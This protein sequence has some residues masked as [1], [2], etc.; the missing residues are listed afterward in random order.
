MLRWTARIL[1]VFAVLSIVAAVIVHFVLKSDWLERVILAAV[2]ERIGM[3]V[4]C[5]SLSVRWGGTTTVHRPAV[6]TPLTNEEVLSADRIEIR[7]EAI[8]LLILGRSIRVRSVEVDSPRVNMRRDENGRWSIQD[9][10][11]RLSTSLSSSDSSAGSQGLPRVMVRDALVRVTEPNT[12]VQ[13]V[14]PLDLRADAEG[15]LLW[16]FD[17]RWSQLAEVKGRV[18]QGSDWTHDVGFSVS[19][20]GSLVRR[21]LGSGPAPIRAAGRWEGKVLQEAVTGTLQLEELVVG[22]AAARG[23]VRVEAKADQICLNPQGLVLSDPHLAGREIHLADGSVR[24]V[25]RQVCVEQ[26]SVVSGRLTARVDGT[27]NWIAGTGELAASWAQLSDG[28]SSQH[29]GVCH[30]S[31]GSPQFG[32]RTAAVSVTAQAETSVGDLALTA[33][34]DGAGADWQKSQWRVSTPTCVWTLDGGQVDLGGAGAEVHVDWPAIRLTSLHVPETQV[35]SAIVQFDP[36]TRAWSANLT[37]DDVSQVEP[38]GIEPLDI[39]LSAEGD[40]HTAH[41]SELRIAQGERIVTARGDLSFR[42]WGFQDVQLTADWP[43]GSAPDGPQAVAKTPGRWH[44]EGAVFGR[45][46]PLAAELTGRLTGQSVAVGKEV[47]EQVEVPVR[48]TA[49][50]REVRVTSDAMDL[51]GGRWL[52]SGRHDLRSNQTEAVVTVDGLSLESVAAIAGL[53]RISQGRT[54]AQIQLAMRDFDIESVVAAG[55]WNAQDVCISPWHIPRARGELHFSKGLA[56]FDQIVLEQENGQ[57]QASVEFR[58]DDP[59]SVCVELT[60]RTW[61]TQLDGDRVT[62]C[63][64]GRARLRVNAID[65]TVN[66][67]ADLSGPVLWAGQPLAH[68]RVS[69]FV[70]K[71]TLDVQELHVDTLGGSVA[72]RAE[73]PLDD[74]RSSTAT[75]GWQG[76][77]P[78][79]LQRWVPQF[80]RFEGL[81]SGSLDVER[82]DPATRPPEPMRFVLDAHAEGGRFGPAHVDSCRLV[83][84]LGS[85]RLLVDEADFDILDGQFEAR[86]RVS[87]HADGYHGSLVVDFNNLSLNQLVH[88]IDPNA[89]EYPGNLAGGGTVL[90]SSDWH[91]FGGEVQVNLTQSDLVSNGV[92]RALHNT[93]NLQLGKQQPTG[94]GEVTVRLEGPSLVIPSFTYYNRGVEIRGTGRIMDI[95]GGSHSPVEGFAVGSTRILRGIRLPGVKAL[96][97]LLVTFQAGAASVKIAGTVAKVET[98]VVPLPEVLG[99]FRSLL[100]AQLH[101]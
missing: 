17:L 5:E 39:H 81:V 91:S 90:A 76:L 40:D 64:D 8:P 75:L 51:L 41:I 44:L 65:R 54:H 9:V 61:E 52:V 45:I 86:T 22:P 21:I 68:V 60:S 99:P 29:S 58:P 66:G 69:S 36:N 84:F 50:P 83:G 73:V 85:R 48:A 94:A 11:T 89:G 18:A 49:N 35:K 92:V 79:L 96:D 67:E 77:Q 33:N 97:Q 28:R 7:H 62:L 78:K 63:T 46:R 3:E 15:P 12:A 74:W 82:A 53:P 19:D 57:V 88:V 23:V 30:A 59:E 93:L 72:G 26:L 95:H 13:T 55:G 34:V 56:R 20:V 70:H 98:T 16:Q 87:A 43:A 14:G 6:K 47:V 100:W 71:R 42:G 4:T 2:G 38:W 37:L 27:W 31:V 1:L 101:K 25:G 32:R 10:W 24:I 80:E